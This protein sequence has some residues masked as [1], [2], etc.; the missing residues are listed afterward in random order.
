MN[1]HTESEWRRALAAAQ[2]QQKRD[3]ALCLFYMAV[4]ALVFGDA[5]ARGVDSWFGRV[6]IWLATV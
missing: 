5:F 4:I 6:F 1:H 3:L 2:R